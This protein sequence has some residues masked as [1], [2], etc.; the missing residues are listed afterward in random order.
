[1]SVV[2]LLGANTACIDDDEFTEKR[3][4]LDEDGDGCPFSNDCDD[5]DVTRGD[6]LV[7]I[8]YD[9]VDNDCSTG[10][11]NIDEV[12]VDG[13]GAPGIPYETWLDNGGKEASWPET[14]PTTEGVVDCRD[15]TPEKI[16]SFKWV[17]WSAEDGSESE[18]DYVPPSHVD[19]ANI[20]P[21][22]SDTVYD[23]V[24]SDCGGENDYDSDGDGYRD[25]DELLRLDLELGSSVPDRPDNLGHEGHFRDGVLVGAGPLGVGRQHD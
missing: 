17:D 15:V 22:A 23:G 3:N 20:L 25:I 6:C 24:D 11:A 18:E 12:D 4:S 7:E 10:S 14:V 19:A 5:H 8:P 9:G 2:L 13:D 1:M 21:G 16:E